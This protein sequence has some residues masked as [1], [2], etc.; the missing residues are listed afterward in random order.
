MSYTLPFQWG[1][2]TYVMGIVNATPDSFSGDGLGAGAEGDGLGGGAGADTDIA[3]I[4]DV[5]AAAVA[6]ARAFVAAG[7]DMLDVGGESTRPGAPRVDAATELARV[8][9]V[10]RAIAAA[11]PVPISIDTYKAEVA[12]AA[13]AAGAHIVNDVTGLAADP[14]MAAVVARAGVPVIV[15]NNRRGKAYENLVPDAVADLAARVVAAERAGIARARIIV[16]PGLGFDRVA[17]HDLALIDELGA[18]KVLGLPILLGPS[19]KRFIA[20]ILGDGTDD[21]AADRLEGTAAA[22]AIGIARGAD[23]VRVHDVGPIV[24]VAR[25]ADA[26]VRRR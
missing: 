17:A 3:D 24:K 23:I 7:A 1:A 16:D 5:V 14:D 19:R 11:V 15:M 20:N 12:A 8:V 2:R 26:I 13:L 9:P 18:F 22:V 25:V 10:V 4:V 6:R 21:P